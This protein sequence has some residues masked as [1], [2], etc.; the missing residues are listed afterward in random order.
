MHFADPQLGFLGGNGIV[1]GGLPM[2]TGMA[3]ARKL[4]RRDDVVIAFL[5]EGGVNQ[6]TFH[7]SLNLASIWTLPVIYVI[8][9]N[10][11]TEYCHYR[12]V[13]AIDTLSDR[14]SGYGMP[15]SMVDGQDV[16]AVHQSIVAAAERARRGE[17]PT[18]LEMRT[19]RF[20]GHHEGEE[21]ILGRNVYRRVEE[22]AEQQTQ[23][24]PISLLKTRLAPEVK[25]QFFAQVEA[26]V[27]QTLQHA[28]RFA[29]E[30]ELPAATDASD[31]VYATS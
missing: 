18:L 1:S 7:E 24:D 16:V 21:Q 25:D 10:L 9:N 22:I 3:L 14:A 30:S 5:G 26:E 28:V 4:D 29:E 12:S 2:A 6:G 31:F 15:G 19:Y 13:T 23:H 27:D 20:R 17:G 11:Y 8:E